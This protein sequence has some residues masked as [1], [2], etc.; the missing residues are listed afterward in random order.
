MRSAQRGLAL[1][2]VVMMLLVLGLLGV[3]L[4][5]AVD[6]YRRQVALQVQAKQVEEA[7]RAGLL[8]GVARYL[9]RGADADGDGMTD[10]PWRGELGAYRW[11]V[12]YCE[13]AQVSSACVAPGAAEPLRLLAQAAS[14]DG[15]I[16]RLVTVRVSSAPLLPRVPAAALLFERSAGLPQGGPLETVADFSTALRAVSGRTLSG[17]LALDAGEGVF[18]GD[19]QALLLRAYPPSAD[20]AATPVAAADAG[21]AD[22]PVLLVSGHTLAVPAGVTVHGL[23]VAP[24]IEM[25]AGSRVVGALLAQTLVADAQARVDHAPLLLEAL[26]GRRLRHVVPHSWRNWQ[27]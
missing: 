14:A 11:Q 17:W 23:L 7:A 9:A 18:D 12:G 4:L 24:R 6:A 8:H 1:L 13:A 20:G 10:A 26:A 15:Q 19:G 22:A 2:F 27:G 16:R 5:S 3:R 25:A 21:S